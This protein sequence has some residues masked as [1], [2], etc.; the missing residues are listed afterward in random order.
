MC[1]SLLGAYC[2]S[3]S[4]SFDALIMWKV[5][6]RFLAEISRRSQ[7]KY[8]SRRKGECNPVTSFR[9]G[10]FMTL[11]CTHTRQGLKS[12]SL[13]SLK[14]VRMAWINATH[15]VDLA[16]LLSQKG[17]QIESLRSQLGPEVVTEAELDDVWLLRYVLSFESRP[18]EAADAARR[19]IAWRNEH[20]E[21]VE[22]AKMR[23]LPPGLSM[24]D[25]QVLQTMLVSGFHFTTKFS[26]P[27]FIIRAGQSNQSP[28]LDMLGEE[29]VEV[30]LT[31]LSECAWQFCDAA[32][33]K[34]GYFVKQITLQDFAAAAMSQDRRFF[35][36][37]G[38][39]SKMNEWLRPQ[40]LGRAIFFN[41]PTWMS[42][43]FA[44]A[45]KIMSQKMLSKIWV[46]RQAVKADDEPHLCPY[47][48]QLLNAEHLPSFLG[49][50]CTCDAHGGCV[51]GMLNSN[52]GKHSADDI[53]SSP[54]TILPLLRLPRCEDIED[55]PHAKPPTGAHTGAP[56]E[57]PAEFNAPR[58]CCK[59]CWRRCS[60]RRPLAA[61]VD[62]SDV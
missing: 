22:A 36:V 37:L 61:S 26:D 43:A 33:R 54:S 53:A 19:A 17:G 6:D 57:S 11:T 39:T 48:Q 50:A 12:E 42:L 28:M 25:V 13:G 35:R 46:H 31:Y 10:F 20:R 27:I 24:G 30:W 60:R 45:S 16:S 44:I 32:T 49:G 4:C 58:S 47:A 56:Q 62:G 23:S 2:E 41:T 9:S 7:D 51:N 14:R 5:A 3:V 29:K 55:G 59:P 18:A 38:K 52:F 40:F 34:R 1:V 8:S 21:L 15:R